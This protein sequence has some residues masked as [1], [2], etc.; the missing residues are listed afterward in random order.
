[1]PPFQQ[2][3]DSIVV[4]GLVWFVE[5]ERQGMQESLNHI[6]MI[7]DI[8]NQKAFRSGHTTSTI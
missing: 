1:M 5:N 7:M 8:S 4:F 2:G 3:K 6:R